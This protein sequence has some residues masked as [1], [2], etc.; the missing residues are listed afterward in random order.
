M[1]LLNAPPM[2]FVPAQWHARKICAMVICYTGD[3]DKTEHALAPIRAL[4]APVVEVLQAW[5]YTR[6]QSFLDEAEPK[7][8]HYYMKTEYVAELSD[9]LLAAVQKAFAECPIPEGQVGLLHLGGAVNERDEDDGVV[10]NRDARFAL[11]VIGMWEA[12]EPN[13]STFRQWVHNGWARVRPFSTGRTYVNFQTADESQERVRATYG[14]NFDRLL[15]VK[16]K[17]DPH[18]MFRRNRNIR[19][20]DAGAL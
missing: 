20:N 13:A 17:Y 18:N 5:P 2:P 3:L 16:E 10:G 9:G 7:G 14:G 6:Q 4:G 1:I 8:S 19:S 15:E 11:G 12:D